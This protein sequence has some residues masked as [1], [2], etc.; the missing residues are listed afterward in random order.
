MI[1]NYIYENMKYCAGV[2]GA[3]AIDLR[4]LYYED[5]VVHKATYDGMKA[6]LSHRFPTLA[7]P[8]QMF[9]AAA[10]A[11]TFVCEMAQRK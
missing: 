5:K 6:L 9:S 7:E 4:Q 8:P 11:D 1:N 3:T 2:T 10:Y